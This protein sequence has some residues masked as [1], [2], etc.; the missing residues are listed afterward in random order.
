[1]ADVSL[2]ESQRRTV[3][4]LR[5]TARDRAV[6]STA[7]HAW[8]VPYGARGR[9]Q[10]CREPVID[11]GRVAQMKKALAVAATAALTLGTFSVAGAAD[12]DSVTIEGSVGTEDGE[13]GRYLRYVGDPAPAGYA[14]N[15]LWGGPRIVTVSPEETP[16]TMTGTLDVSEMIDGT[17]AVIGLHDLQALQ[18]QERGGKQGVGIYVNAE[19]GGVYEVGVTDGD[20]GGGEFAQVSSFLSPEDGVMD[21]EFTVDGSCS[22]EPDDA[23]GC[24]TLIVDEVTM[25]DSYGLIKPANSAEQELGE[26][27]QPGWYVYYPQAVGTPVIGVSYDLNVSPATATLSSPDDCKDGGFAQFGFDNQ[28]E[29]IRSLIAADPQS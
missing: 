21:V 28:G 9:A 22:P 17:V 5:I 15:Y 19:G 16:V 1:V 3:R 8:G 18:S 25:T 29:C 10:R 4:I 2:G 6:G 7:G 27:A 13:Q 24:M 11:H 20:S 12:H 14:E 26:G 23:A